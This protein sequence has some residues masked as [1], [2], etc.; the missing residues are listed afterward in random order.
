MSEKEMKQE[1]VRAISGYDDCLDCDT[2]IFKNCC[3][4]KEIAENLWRDGWR[5][6]EKEKEDESSKGSIDCSGSLGID[7]CWILCGIDR[8]AGP[9]TQ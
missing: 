1:L 7:M 4:E 9:C 8:S 5:K 6:I 2:C 3:A